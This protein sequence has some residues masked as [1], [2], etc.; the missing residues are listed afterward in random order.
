MPHPSAT[1][2][3]KYGDETVSVFRLIVLELELEAV[4]KPQLRRWLT[5]SQIVYL[6]FLSQILWQFEFEN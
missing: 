5:E 2:N 4:Y 1:A 6:W 3:P